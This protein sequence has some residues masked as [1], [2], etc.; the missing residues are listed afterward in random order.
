[1]PLVDFVH[2]IE[3]LTAYAKAALRRYIVEQASRHDP[4]GT[5]QPR[6]A[7][8]A[9]E[10]IK[11]LSG[12]APTPAAAGD[13]AYAAADASVTEA[14]A[15]VAKILAADPEAP[16]A[17]LARVG[18]LTDQDV[19]IVAVLLAPELDPDFERAYA[20]ACDDFTKK[21]TDVAFVM[22]MVGGRDRAAREAVRQALSA[23]G[24]LRRA[25]L[26]V[27]SE[28]RE[29]STLARPVKLTDRVIDFL[30]GDDRVDDELSGVAVLEENALPL[31]QVV[32]DPNLKAQLLRAVSSTE[33]HGRPPRI[34]VFGPPGS[35]KKTL[36]AAAAKAAG[37]DVLTVDLA[38]LLTADAEHIAQRLAPVVREGVLRRA[39]LLFEMAGV[40]GALPARAGNALSS[41]IHD[42]PSPVVFVAL[43]RPAWL[44]AGIPS[45]VELAVPVPTR[46]ERI[47][48]WRRALASQKLTEPQA[49]EIVATRYSFGGGSISR[50]A[51][52]AISRS[53]LRA[54]PGEP[55]QVKL[56]D[57]A[58]ASRVQFSHRLGTLAQRIPPGFS[59]DDLVVPEDT[60]ERIQE[61]IRFAV[62]REYLLGEW[63][64][65][66]KLPYGRGVSALFV[67]PPGTGKT[68]VA[69]LIGQEIGYELYR[70]DLA[71]VVNKYIGETEK[72]L[73]RVFDEA[74]QSHAILF[75][76]EADSLFAKR[77]DVKSSVDR[78]AN[79]EVN[80]LLQRMEMYDG[81]TILASNLQQAMDE[82]FK[83]RVRFTVEFEMPD[84]DTRKRLWRSMFPPEAPLARDIDW[85]K[86]ARTFEMA[87]GHIK[88]VAIRAALMAVARGTGT[89][90]N[91][92]D[93]MEAGRLEYREM[94]RMV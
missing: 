56:E 9:K 89:S 62:H 38:G 65:Q 33:G 58:E 10:M 71:Q 74:E 54:K 4:D 16:I 82:A 46:A 83:R 87:G 25:R 30:R 93:L 36:I 51:A 57:L 29:A 17:R 64:F 28:A 50:A 90:I 31:D 35:G 52:R 91:N 53:W 3:A 63:G 73:A 68:M 42:T 78:Y 22:G 70:I 77:T 45:L 26:I 44:A 23:E 6:Y 76:D 86:L 34:L 11:F 2:L 21:R 47:E 48:L 61:I 69:G 12:N 85:D 66:K 39:V 1:M 32:A 94:G 92:G 81:V 67:G 75:F 72:N 79:L 19:R 27:V 84:V 88:K 7:V 13:T 55:P 40:E 49:V 18:G 14:A 20:A 15:S 41:V 8:G 5:G 80:Y 60:A 43:D 59:W 37:L 24:A